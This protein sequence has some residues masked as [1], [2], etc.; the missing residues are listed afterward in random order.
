MFTRALLAVALVACH[1]G[2]DRA[3]RP[4][5]PDADADPTQDAKYR[6]FAS[7]FNRLQRKVYDAWHPAEVWQLV[8]P[9][10]TIYGHSDRITEVRVCL[11]R[12][13]TLVAILVTL[14]S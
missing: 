2:G 5:E 6:I 4:G 9:R 3:S 1:L 14:S 7:Y 13:G 8:D 10:G 11:S 12:N